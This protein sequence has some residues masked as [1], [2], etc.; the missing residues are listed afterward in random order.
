MQ[1]AEDTLGAESRGS[2]TVR[3]DSEDHA[4]RGRGGGDAERRARHHSL[5]GASRGPRGTLEKKDA[6]INELQARIKLFIDEGEVED[7]T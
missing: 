6:V 7:E 2:A 1:T 4:R 5:Q 3:S